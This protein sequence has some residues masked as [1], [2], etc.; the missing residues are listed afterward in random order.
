MLNF[1]F[2]A[3]GNEYL[4]ARMNSQAPEFTFA[5]SGDQTL[6]ARCLLLYLVDLVALC[7]DYD[8]VL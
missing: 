8:L 5:V 1:T 3:S 6:Q 2:I 7:S 4:L